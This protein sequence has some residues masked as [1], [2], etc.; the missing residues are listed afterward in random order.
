M[1]FTKRK[2]FGIRRAL[3]TRVEDC[4]SKKLRLF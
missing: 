1:S 2:G 4:A 3:T